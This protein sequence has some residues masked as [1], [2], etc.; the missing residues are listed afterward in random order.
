MSRL[1][2]TFSFIRALPALLLFA[3]LIAVL[4]AGW[5]LL[6]I[7]L[8]PWLGWWGVTLGLLV[9]WVVHSLAHACGYFET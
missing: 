3:L 1:Y 9:W 8:F 7:A 2:A 6:P 4:Y 5:L